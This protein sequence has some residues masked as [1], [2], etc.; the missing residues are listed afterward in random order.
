MPIV[1]VQGPTQ[2]QALR[3][4]NVL[5]HLRTP[6]LGQEVF[7]WPLKGSN[8]WTHWTQH[9]PNA[10]V[11]ILRQRQRQDR[12]S[13]PKFQLLLRPTYQLRLSELLPHQLK[14]LP[15]LSPVKTLLPPLY[16]LLPV[17]ALKICFKTWLAGRRLLRR[18]VSG[19]PES[20]LR[21]LMIVE[22]HPSHDAEEWLQYYYSRLDFFRGIE[23]RLENP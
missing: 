4:S 1:Q 21:G 15:Q 13:V 17:N 5:I 22:Q 23:H 18:C 2:R 7:D 19:I 9:L 16:G 11:V 10:L 8:L 14:A 20:S 12:L 6:V 3:R